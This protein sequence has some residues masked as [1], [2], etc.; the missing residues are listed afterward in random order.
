[1]NTIQFSSESLPHLDG[2]NPKCPPNGRHFLLSGER[3]TV[4]EPFMG[5]FEGFG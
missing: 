4:I 1:M 3:G 2:I 5:G